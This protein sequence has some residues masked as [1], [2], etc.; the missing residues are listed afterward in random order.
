MTSEP[1]EAVRP[2]WRE[3]ATDA[4]APRRVRL[5]RLPA[6]DGSAALIAPSVLLVLFLAVPLGALLYRTLQSGTLGG[7]LSGPIV[8]PAL[9]LSLMTSAVALGVTIALGTPL[10]YLLARSRFRG[11]QIV[12]TLID[13]PMVMPPV[14][15]GVALLMAFGRR[16]VFGGA[17]RAGGIDL[18]F[19]TDAVILAQIF[20]S[21]PFYIRAVRSGFRAIEPE[22]EQVAYTM[23]A[24]RLQALRFV[25]VPLAM[26]ALAGGAALCWARAMGEFGATM[27]F[28]GNFSGTTRTASLAIMTAFNDD[29]YSALALAVVLLAVS[30]TVLG[31]FRL[32]TRNDLQL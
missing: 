1:S 10:A 3:G 15:A 30:A 13:L 23:G 2:G 4:S 29:L 22:L 16:G 31:V 26:P 9:R 19:T 7:A 12:E 6:G 21:A 11:Q 25:T 8:W 14:V 17:L 32:L 24:S 20:V 5:R 28:A 27:M 18:A